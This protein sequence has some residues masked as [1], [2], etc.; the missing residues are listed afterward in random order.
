MKR[1][2]D[3]PAIF[4]AITICNINPYYE[5]SR[6]VVR[7]LS[8]KLNGGEC[9]NLTN[10]EQFKS[11]FMKAFP[12]LDSLSNA[13]DTFI[14]RLNRLVAADKNLTLPDANVTLAGIGFD[15]VNDMIVTCQYNEAN[16]TEI[17]NNSTMLI[18]RDNDRGN[19]YTLNSMEPLLK[20]SATGERYGLHL[21]I[22]VRK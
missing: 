8:N 1:I 4:P 9:F 2:N 3:L 22:V 13:F 10:G 6:K 12:H 17:L 15:I 19:C 14:D 16:C 21:E 18:F 5:R 7:Y 11:C 20:T